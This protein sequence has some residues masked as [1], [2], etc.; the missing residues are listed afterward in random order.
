MGRTSKQLVVAL[1]GCVGLMA[2]PAVLSVLRTSVLVGML[3]NCYYRSGCSTGLCFALL[4][5]P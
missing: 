4:K 5:G 3:Q 1:A 2:E